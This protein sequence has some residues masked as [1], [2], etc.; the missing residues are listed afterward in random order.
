M[1]LY[2][3]KTNLL[4]RVPGQHRETLTGKTKTNKTRT[5]KFESQHENRLGKSKWQDE[6]GLALRSLFRKSLLLL[7]CICAHVYTVAHEV[8]REC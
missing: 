2:E 4:Y 6:K 7:I 3:F 1:D 8:R 5:Q